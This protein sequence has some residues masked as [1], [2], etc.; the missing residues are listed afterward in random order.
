[1][2]VDESRVIRVLMAG[3]LPPP[4]GGVT[5]LFE[6]LARGLSAR[7][8]VRVSVVDTGGVRGQGV[9]S[10]R[11]LARLLARMREEARRVD[12]VTLHAATSGLHVTGPLAVLAARASGRP[13]IVRKFGGTDFLTYGPVRRV[14]IRW[15]LAR[16]SLY[17]AETRA[18]VKA[19]RS[20]GLRA[21][22]Y[23][24]SREMP[25]LPADTARDRSTCRRFVFL[26]QVHSRKGV[27]ELIRAGEQLPNGATVDV[28]GPLDFDVGE[29]E[30]AG[31]RRV[32]YAGSVRPEDVH[33]VLSRY[34]ALVLPSY[35]E[36]EGYPGVVL[37]AFAAGLPV[38]STRWRAIPE[39][40]EDGETGLLVAPC[41]W[42]HLRRAMTALTSDA[43]LCARLRAGVR[44]K[45]H[46]FSDTVWHEKFVDYCRSVAG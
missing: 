23:P 36:G 7:D 45:R 16:T 28:Y 6:S 40:I 5:V 43:E 32:R 17:L 41:D 37:E 27:R 22:W 46:E 42:A 33:R 15:A 13:L 1:M 38:V 25:L 2:E 4:L 24:N 11:A 39:L 35:H 8:D 34:D 29:H 10:G 20:A 26:G 44:A 30:F 12:V 31:L 3:P 14:L 18:L 21:E 19:A 9:G